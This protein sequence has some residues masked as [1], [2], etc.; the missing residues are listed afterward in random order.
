MLTEH[1]LVG[2]LT[3]AEIF[4]FSSPFLVCV[5]TAAAIAKS[6]QVKRID[7]MDALSD[8]LMKA[9]YSEDPFHGLAVKLTTN[10]EP[11]LNFLRQQ[12][13]FKDLDFDYKRAA[14]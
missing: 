11:F 1:Y 6:L 13:D 12:Y 2:D 8:I 14:N 4:I 9:W 5:E 10:K 7:V 3:E